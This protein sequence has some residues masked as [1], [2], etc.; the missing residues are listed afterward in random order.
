MAVAAAWPHSWES[1]WG[2]T[3]ASG[4]VVTA[5]ELILV[6]RTPNQLTGPTLTDIGPLIAPTI[7]YSDVLNGDGQLQCSVVPD[8]LDTDVKGALR[9]LMN[10]SIAPDPLELHLY[11]DGAKVWAGPLV[12]WQVQGGTLTLDARG[13]AY[14]LRY[15]WATSDLTYSS[16]DQY[17]IAAALV[18]HWQNLD[19]GHYGIDTSSVGTSGI[20]RTRTYLA[21]EH[22]N[23]HEAVTSLGQVTNGFDWWIASDGTLNVTSQRGSDRTSEIVFDL[24]NITN[25]GIIGSVAADDVASEGFGLATDADSEPLTSTQGNASVRQTFGRSGVAKTFDGVTVQTTLDGHTRR[26]IDDRS[27]ALFV[28]GPE[29]IPVADVRPGDFGP[30]DIVEWS[31]DAGLGLQTFNRRLASVQISVDENGGETMSVAML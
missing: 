8:K 9:G 29:L 17:A 10:P 31:F 3:I 15:M 27:G 11:R 14:Y 20:T 24:R 12:G 13:M 21:A 4:N 16:T 26:L 22:H 30:G 1:V 25:S 23:I 18:D 7:T 6:D 5:Y 2:M 19:Y 28:P